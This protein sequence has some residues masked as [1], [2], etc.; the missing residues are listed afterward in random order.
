M[1]SQPQ[2]RWSLAFACLDTVF[3]QGSILP[4]STILKKY[5][6]SSC[7]KNNNKCILSNYA[8]PEPFSRRSF[9][10]ISTSSRIFSSAI[11]ASKNCRRISLFFLRKNLRTDF[12]SM[13]LPMRF[14][15]CFCL[16]SIRFLML[17]VNP[18][19]S[20]AKPWQALDTKS[21]VL[22]WLI[23]SRNKLRF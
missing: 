19:R 8:V 9:T 3:S 17:E 11:A 6:K 15:L 7:N 13:C 20:L 2:K 22:L 1:L 5:C 12:V 23:A 16:P 21:K 14:L 10:M 4:T 18:R